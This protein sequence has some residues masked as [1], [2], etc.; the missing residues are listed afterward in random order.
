[1]LGAA[2]SYCCRTGKKCSRIASLIDNPASRERLHAASSDHLGTFD[3]SSGRKAPVS[4]KPDRC[5]KWSGEILPTIPR[6]P[7]VTMPASVKFTL[8]GE[9][10]IVRVRSAPK[11][12]A[13]R[14]GTDNR[15]RRR[16]TSKRAARLA[17]S[18]SR[19]LFSKARFAP[20]LWAK[21]A[22]LPAVA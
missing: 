8:C 15:E 13:R 22:R 2:R 7:D 19:Q 18:L 11:G 20:F 21:C 5:E 9:M 1:M 16:S 17:T 10:K 14:Q 3:G 12:V 6:S 4:G